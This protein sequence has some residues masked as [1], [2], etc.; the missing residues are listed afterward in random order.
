MPRTRPGLIPKF[1]H[2]NNRL[3]SQ[4][5]F[6]LRN[7]SLLVATPATAAIIEPPTTAAPRDPR[8]T[9]PVQERVSPIDPPTA[10]LKK[11]STFLPLI[12]GII[13]RTFSLGLYFSNPFSWNLNA[14][15]T[16]A[17]ITPIRLIMIWLWGPPVAHEPYQVSIFTS[18]V[19]IQFISPWKP[20]DLVPV[21]SP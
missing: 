18:V 14:I 5:S 20:V 21:V 3:V 8:D 19:E 17:M 10:F 2:K 1:P 11:A 16:I 15:D 13:P 4:K 9:F 12:T 7:S 6:D